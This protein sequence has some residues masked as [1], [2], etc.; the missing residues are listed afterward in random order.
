[1]WR[2]SSGN[3]ILTDAEW[4]LFRFGLESLWGY[5]ETEI[6]QGFSLTQTG[7]QVFDSLQPEQRLALLADVAQALRDPA[8]PIPRHTAV[9][10]G[11]IAAVFAMLRNEVEGEILF[12]EL[13]TVSTE[14]RA[15]VLAA[16]RDTEQQPESLPDIAEADIEE[17]EWVVEAILDRILW[18][19]DYE[20]GDD[21]LDQPPEAS[22][23]L[24][25]QVRIDPDYFTTVPREPDRAGM[26]AVRQLLA[27]LV[28]SAVPDDDGLYP[29]LEDL[30]HELLVGPCTP[31][32][33]AGWADHP[34]LRVIQ[35]DEPVFD[36]TF[37]TWV[38]HFQDKLPGEAFELDRGLSGSPARRLIWPEVVQ[39]KRRGD[40]W[41]IR[42]DRGEFWCDALTNCWSD[43]PD[44][45]PMLTFPSRKAARAAYRHASKMYAERAARHEAAIDL[46]MELEET[47]ERPED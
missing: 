9:N 42:N 35:V 38:E 13:E 18:D 19:R 44:E 12:T 27:R 30:Y 31:E 14:I 40:V 2:M 10:E 37:T 46:L 36:C 29:A 17:W 32:Q 4:N 25:S 16:A 26:L 33:I 23:D 43:D 34:W 41:V 11:A 7:V 3:R 21:F 47:G 6:E 8:I 5:I 22:R 39:V 15:L 28:G 24:H 20:M 1:M 45:L